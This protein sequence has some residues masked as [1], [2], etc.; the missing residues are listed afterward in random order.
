LDIKNTSFAY[1]SDSYK[2]SVFDGELIE[3][4]VPGNML[5]QSSGLV[6]KAFSNLVREWRS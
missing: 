3:S 2:Y 4:D 6:I 1:N 5:G